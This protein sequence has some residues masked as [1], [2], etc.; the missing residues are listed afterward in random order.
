MS[1]RQH[2]SAYV[3]SKGAPLLLR[4]ESRFA[5]QM[6]LLLA[7]LLLLV[8]LLLL[9][10]MRQHTSANVSIRQ[11]YLL[12]LLLL[13]LLQLVF[14]AISRRIHHEALVSWCILREIMSG[15][16]AVLEV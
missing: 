12:L 3:G 16:A 15:W 14:F 11:H 4:N 8:L 2:T 7:L 6:H 9:L 5:S 10:L 1:I 13:L